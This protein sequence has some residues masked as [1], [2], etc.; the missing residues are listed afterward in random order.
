MKV[1]VSGNHDWII[2]LVM[3]AL[4]AAVHTGVVFVVFMAEP[5]PPMAAIEGQLVAPAEAPPASVQDALATW[6]SR[7]GGREE[8]MKTELNAKLRTIDEQ[9][10]AEPWTQQNSA[11][12]LRSY[13]EL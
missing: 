10:S 1:V 6:R 13:A 3:F 4:S 7:L 12:R 11:S 9:R 5:P 8:E 2:Y